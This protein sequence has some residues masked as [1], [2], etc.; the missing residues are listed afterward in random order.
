MKTVQEIND[1]IK[2]GTAVVMT[3][4]EVIAL[5]REQGVTEAARK[6]DVVT[7]GTFSPMCSSGAFLNFG[8]AEPLIRMSSVS[9]NDVSCYAGLAAVDC[10]LGAT[11]L[12]A[13]KGMEY[14]GA[15]V[16]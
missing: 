6:V 7:T 2:S 8:H 14:G 1:K 16:G 9:L 10:Y 3:A 12:S 5:V 15:N 4:E 11:E 13:T